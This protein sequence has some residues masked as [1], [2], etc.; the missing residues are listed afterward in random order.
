MTFELPYFCAMGFL[1]RRSWLVVRGL[2]LILYTRR[3]HTSSANVI[4]RLNDAR[5]NLLLT[6]L[7]RP[8]P[9]RVTT[10][11]NRRNLTLFTSA[12]TST[13]RLQLRSIGRISRTHNSMLGVNIRR[14]LTSLITL[15]RDV[16]NNTTTSL[17][18]TTNRL[19][20]DTIKVLLRNTA[21]L[22]SRAN[23]QNMNL[24]TTLTTTN[25]LLTIRRSR[26][27]T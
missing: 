9:L 18:R 8:L 6:M 26:N 16:G 3:N 17:V 24:P 4:T 2:W 7:T 14:L 23:D 10:S 27:I 19:P 13:R 1:S 20:R 15:P 12:T 22:A 5:L 11:K 25:T 21:N